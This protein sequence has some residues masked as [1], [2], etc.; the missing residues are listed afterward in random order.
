MSGN[1]FFFHQAKSV[2]F[3]ISYSASIQSG[4]RLSGLMTSA[5]ASERITCT[6]SRWSGNATSR[7]MPYKPKISAGS[8]WS[9]GPERLYFIQSG[10]VVQCVARD[11]SLLL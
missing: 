2:Q 3:Y 10:Y 8:Y 4:G 7:L 11:P 6:P 1:V 5:P 9:V